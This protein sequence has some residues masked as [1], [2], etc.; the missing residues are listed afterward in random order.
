[1]A[2]ND[3]GKNTRTW[4]K[5]L[6]ETILPYR[7]YLTTLLLM[8]SWPGLIPKIPTTAPTID[9]FI[10]DICHFG[11]TPSDVLNWYDFIGADGR[12][13]YMHVVA[14]D[15]FILIP[16]YSSA[17]FLELHLALPDHL[18]ETMVSCLPFLATMFDLVETTTHGYGVAV[19]SLGHRSLLPSESW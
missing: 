4:R 2:S 14:F 6:L 3:N 11:Y 13:Q 8:A 1:M 19:L 18:S 9:C 16:L 12:L 15:L 10:P 5:R 7:V 17:L